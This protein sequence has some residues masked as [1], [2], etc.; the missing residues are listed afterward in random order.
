M[1]WKYVEDV[2]RELRRYLVEPD[3]TAISEAVL[4]SWMQMAYDEFRHEVMKT[5]EWFYARKATITLTA[6]ETTLSS[7]GLS[8]A[9]AAAGTSLER[10]VGIMRVSGNRKEQLTMGRT[11]VDVEEGSADAV[12]LG[13]T[14]RMASDP[15]GKTLELWYVPSQ[16]VDWSQTTA[17]DNEFIDDLLSF[18]DIIALIAYLHF[19]VVDAAEHPQLLRL[20]GQRT[21]TLRRHLEKRGSVDTYAALI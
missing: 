10:L 6:Y 2:A 3:Q 12:L 15:T 18:H 19:A 21:Q 5:D 20:L 13:D 17:G 8:G 14:L 4:Q 16:S 1:S 7:L 11:M 9:A